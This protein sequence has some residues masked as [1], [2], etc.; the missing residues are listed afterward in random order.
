[1]SIKES[2]VDWHDRVRFISCQKKETNQKKRKIRIKQRATTTSHTAYQQRLV[3]RILSVCNQ[4]LSCLFLFCD[5]FCVY[6]FHLNARLV[7]VVRMLSTIFVCVY[8]LIFFFHI[9]FS[10]DF[11]FLF[12]FFFPQYSILWIWMFARAMLRK[13]LIN[14]I[15]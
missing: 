15:A 5:F 13:T 14:V 3:L 11:M 10:L 1:M 12:S 4:R 7:R 6:L 2:A 9:L 8:T